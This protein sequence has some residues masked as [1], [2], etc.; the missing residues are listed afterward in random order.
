M[1]KEALKIANLGSTSFFKRLPTRKPLTDKVSKLLAYFI[2][3]NTKKY[4]S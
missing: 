2:E 1:S 3:D 4:L